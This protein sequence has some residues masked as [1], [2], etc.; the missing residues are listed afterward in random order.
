MARIKVA[1]VGGGS[2]R[3]PGTVASFV[4]QGE[5]FSGSEVVLID[6]DVE[7]LAVVEALG[8]GMS[9]AS[10]VDLTFSHT[11]DRRAGLEDCDAVLTSFR[12]GGFGARHLDE[13]IPLRHGA[14]GQETQ[15][16]GGFFMALRSVSEFRR[17]VSEMEE[18]CSKAVLFNYTNPVNIVSEAVTRHSGVTTVSLCEGPI[19]CPRE[20]AAA[21]GLDPDLVDGVSVGLNHASFSVRHLYDGEDMI[22]LLAAAYERERKDTSLGLT[23]LRRLRLAAAL[24]CVPSSYMQYYFFEEEVLA[25][26]K[27][28]PTTRAQDIMAEEKD[29]WEHYEE[30]ASSDIPVLDPSLSRTG[31]NELELGVDVMD[32]YFNNRGELW[33]V[34]VV[35]R[36]SVP[37]LPDDMVVETVAHVDRTGFDPVALGGL[38]P[39]AAGL[40]GRLAEYQRLAADA[41]WDGSRADAVKALLSNPLVR[42]LEKAEALY[43]EMSAAHR[44][45]L[46]Q[47]LLEDRSG[48][49]RC[50]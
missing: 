35:N 32:A 22:P 1:Y 30:Q 49:A 36:G 40:V 20:L 6:L 27:A 8:N 34:N 3:A 16:P 44:E 37:E 31:V 12:P 28:K 10:G 46:P 13:S 19:V 25:E 26:L 9:S 7:R 50:A 5:N 33:P 42:S 24:G 2:T 11:T 4:E 41:A 45:F 47:R 38:P 15:G 21:A 39:V 48:A 18:L 23:D 43:A 17:I 14:I 29:Y